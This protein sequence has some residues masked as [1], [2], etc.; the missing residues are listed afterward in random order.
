MNDTIL[1]IS[2]RPGLCRLLK[3]GRGNL[4]VESIDADKKR[5]SVG[6][7]ERVTSLND[8]SMYSDDDDVAL[9]QVF[10]NIYDKYKGT[11]PLSHKTAKDSELEAFMAE[12][13]PTY[14]RDRVHLSDIKK[15]IQWY[16]ILAAAGYKEFVVAE[17][18]T[19][20]EETAAAEAEGKDK[21]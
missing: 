20:T 12:A 18:E 6:A 16:N 11:A 10:Q 2:G 8:V 14:D 4:I 7:R 3:Q 19:A 21:E 5:F 15:L 1:A 17:S 13:L 9:M